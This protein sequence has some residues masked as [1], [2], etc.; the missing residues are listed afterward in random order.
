MRKIQA[1]MSGALDGLYRTNSSDSI[2]SF[3]ESID[4]K[5]YEEFC[6]TLYRKGIGPDVLFQKENEIYDIF[7]SEKPG[8]RGQIGDIT[9]VGQRQFSEV[10]D[11]AGAGAGASAGWLAWLIWPL[12]AVG[13]N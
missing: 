6:Y 10:C 13:L 5:A 8:I 7:K 4:T 1:Q 2:T 3:T 11:Y 9:T 12:N